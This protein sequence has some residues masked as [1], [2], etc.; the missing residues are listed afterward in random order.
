M[1]KRNHQNCCSLGQIP[2]ICPTAAWN[3]T[4]RT[5]AGIA[6]VASSSATTFNFVY[7]FYITSNNTLIVSD[8]NNNRVQRFNPG[9]VSGTTLST[10]P[11]WNPAGLDMDNNGALYVLDSSNFRVLRWINNVATVVAGGRGAG[12]AFDRMSTSYYIFVDTAANIYLSDYSNHRVTFWA[13]NNPNIS[14]LVSLS[15]ITIIVAS[16]CQ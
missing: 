4:F 3:Q 13:A 15:L 14:Q 9:V 2:V 10:I 8:F 7:D 6:G 1:L 11:V 12:S 5:L 16:F